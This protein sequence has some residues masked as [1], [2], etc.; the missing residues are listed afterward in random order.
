MEITI[1]CYFE[2]AFSYILNGRSLIVTVLK[3][4]LGLPQKVMSNYINHI[5]ENPSRS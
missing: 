5:A 2:Y 4:I 1:N 3:V